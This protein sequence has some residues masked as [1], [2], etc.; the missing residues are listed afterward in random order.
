MSNTTSKGLGQ[1]VSYE[2]MQSNID[3]SPNM[4]STATQPS[5]SNQGLAATMN[6]VRREKAD[7]MSDLAKTPDVGASTKNFAIS[8]ASSAASNQNFL[9]SLGKL[10]D[11]STINTPN[12]A[13]NVIEI[14]TG[15]GQGFS[16]TPEILSNLNSNQNA[17][18]GAQPAV[19][20]TE[21]GA[22]GAGA[23]AGSMSWGTYAMMGAQLAIQIYSAYTA[24]KQMKETIKLARDSL[25]AQKESDL[26]NFEASRTGYNNDIKSREFSRY[27]NQG[28]SQGGYSG[29]A[30]LV[31]ETGKAGGK[32][33]DQAL[34]DLKSNTNTVP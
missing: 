14:S 25:N 29:M 30:N 26:R 19:G 16:T 6:K 13:S 34:K 17:L 18:W 15:N 32:A 23:G 21:A 3:Y 10:F 4:T 1:I 33:L 9:N 12:M 24:H 20:G 27:M 2:S 11:G 28:G 22:S 5:N 31:D 7:A 8:L